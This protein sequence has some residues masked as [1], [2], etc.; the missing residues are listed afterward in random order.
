MKTYIGDLL[1]SDC[2]VLVHCANIYHTFGSGIAYFIK[3]RFPEAYA[4]DLE[5]EC[6]CESKLGTF[7]KAT[8]SNNRVLYNLYAMYGI[9]NDGHPLNRNL[10][11]DH[12]YNGLYE[13]CEDALKETNNFP[14]T[15]GL[16]KYIGCCRAGGNWIIVESIVQ[17]IEKL[18]HNVE[19]HIYELENA[20][21]TA[22]STKPVNL[23]KFD[24]D[25]FCGLC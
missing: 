20:E 15:I 25:D 10:S 1:D 4:A 14:I 24:I 8:I 3:K 22:Q 19:F 13:I 23:S 21:T 12:L 2:D 9:G 16:P 18:F 7:S 11:Y 17:E 5:T 6:G